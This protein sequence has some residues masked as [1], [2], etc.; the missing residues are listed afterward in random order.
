MIQVSDPGAL[1]RAQKTEIDAAVARVLQGGHYILGPEVEAF[2]AEFASW[3]GAGAGACV[4]CANGTD[5]LVL[6]LRGLGLG[7]G[8]QVATVSHT[9]VATVA[10]IELAGAE[11]VLLDVDA[12]RFTL[13]P[14][15]LKDLL[16][17]GAG[18][19]KAVVV[20]HLYGQM[21]DMPAIEALCQRHGLLLIEDCAQA[22]GATLDGR[23]AGTWGDAASFSF[24]PTKNLG[25][26]GDGGAATFQLLVHAERAR[27]LRQYGWRER[28]ISEISGFNSRLD[29]LQAAVLRV[30]LP[31]LHAGNA[32]RQAIAARYDQVLKGL[33]WAF[34][35][36]ADKAA[37]VYHQY[38]LRH[39]RRDA[40]A[41]HL[42]AQGVASSV[43]YPQPVHLQPAYADRV[44]LGPTGLAATEALVLEILS[45]PVHPQLSDAD[46]GTICA[47]LKSFS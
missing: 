1:Y 44:A 28:Y 16:A 11:A 3:L 38:T 30:K 6:A 32:R 46:V 20:V 45:L 17:N 18:R 13:D 9:A 14:E 35:S 40:L 41:G 34:P 15:A 42:K 26:L 36:I 21:A 12:R 7:A 31:A 37:S 24:Y 43:L 39:P 25:A 47:A 2:E 8:D 4:S 10:A 33:G 5:A 23:M 29:E 22:H 27:L 19:L